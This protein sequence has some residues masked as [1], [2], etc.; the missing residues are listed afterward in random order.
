VLWTCGDLGCIDAMCR[1][2]SDPA[3]VGEACADRACR[4]GFCEPGTSRCTPFLAEGAPCRDDVQCDV[5]RCT[6]DRTAGERRCLALACPGDP[7][8]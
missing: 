3:A 4:E 5:G 6:L 1:P 2:W 7:A 8:R